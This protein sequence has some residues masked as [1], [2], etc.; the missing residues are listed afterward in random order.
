MQTARNNRWMPQLSDDICG[1]QTPEQHVAMKVLKQAV[2]D[3]RILCGYGL[4]T[5]AGKC[6]RWPRAKRSMGRDPRH[7]DFMIIAGMKHPLD[8]KKLRDWF[9]ALDQGQILCDLIGWRMPCAEIFWHIVRKE[10]AK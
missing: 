6:K 3:L 2:D 9:L 7:G 4:I 1:A 10:G 5:K 8:H